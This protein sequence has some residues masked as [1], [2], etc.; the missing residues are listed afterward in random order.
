MFARE[1][2]VEVRALRPDLG[3]PQLEGVTS[4]V[5]ASAR[6]NGHEATARLERSL[7]EVA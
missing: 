4:S 6:A 7:E 2:D 5:A 1:L 3:R